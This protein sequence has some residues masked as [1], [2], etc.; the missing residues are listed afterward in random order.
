MANTTSW[1]DK[2]KIVY[3]LRPQLFWKKSLKLMR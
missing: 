3:S 2:Q 1:F